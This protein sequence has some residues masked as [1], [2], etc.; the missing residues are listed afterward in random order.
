MAELVS[1]EN[2]ERLAG[3]N[4]HHHSLETA[5]PLYICDFRGL[6]GAKMPGRLKTLRLGRPSQW[7]E[8]LDRRIQIPSY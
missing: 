2:P 3:N 6:R 7:P 8:D 4:N 5:R 1:F